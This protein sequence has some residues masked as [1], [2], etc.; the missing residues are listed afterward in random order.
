MPAEILNGKILAE[1]IHQEIIRTIKNQNAQGMRA[2]GLA[3]VLLGQ[4]PASEIYVKNKLMATEK[5]G[6]HSKA[7]YLPKETTEEALLKLINELNNNPDIDGILVQLPLPS[8]I[9]ANTVVE[10]IAVNKDVDG[11][12]PY[13]LG[14]LAQKRPLL[15]P[16]TPAGV[17]K[18][19]ET[20]GIDLK[21]LDA[22]VVGVSNIVGRPMIL[23]LLMK[24]CPVTACHHLT[25]DL[26]KNVEA[27]DLVVVAV[28]KPGLIKGDW[29]K[30]GAIVIDIGM[31]RMDNG[32]FIG[33]VE[34]EVAKENAAYITP[35]P[36]GVGPMTVATLLSNTLQAYQNTL[37]LSN[38]DPGKHKK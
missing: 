32:H 29:I 17:I 27:A 9:N 2:P 20:T 35:V 36:G 5:V 1:K 23:E 13:N 31:N 26:K 7:Y 30:S 4:D 18:L 12:H 14:R 10:S 37:A 22:T 11:F 24:G 15:R 28:G 19:L 33:D 16:C 3:V 25:K 21:G 8:H 6:I 38:R 34:F